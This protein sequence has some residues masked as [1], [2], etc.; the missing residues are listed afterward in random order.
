MKT[1]T[2]EVTDEQA[3]TIER[4]S[5]SRNLIF[6]NGQV[7]AVRFDDN[8]VTCYTIYKQGDYALEVRDFTD[9]GWRPEEEGE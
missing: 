5:L 8:S 4:L 7:G 3:Y 1:Y 2:F 6:S 9:E